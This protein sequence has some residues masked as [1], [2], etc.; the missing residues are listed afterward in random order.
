MGTIDRE[1]GRWGQLTVRVGGGDK[2][3][4]DSVYAAWLNDD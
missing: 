4:G 3:R 1:V 2:A